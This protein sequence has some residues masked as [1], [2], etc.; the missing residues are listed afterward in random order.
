[1]QGIKQRSAK[2]F[3]QFSLEEA[4]PAD[5]I[6]RRI[7]QSLDLS[8][9]YPCTRRLYGKDGQ[10]SIDPVVFFKMCLIGYLNDITADRALCRYIQ[11]SLAARWFICHDIDEPIP[12][13]STLS[14]TRALFGRPLYEE[15]FRRVLALCVD[16]GL[17]SGTRQAVDSGLVK[18]NAS[19]DSMRRRV[20]ME[21]A[22]AWCRQVSS[23]NAAEQADSGGGPTPVELPARAPR[24]RSR[25][26]KTHQSVTDPDARLARKPGKPTDM[27]YHGQI[28]VDAQHGVIV[29]AMADYA[30]TEDHQSL[31]ALLDQVQAHLSA[32]HLRVEE[33]LADSKYNTLHTIEACE[34][35]GITAY[36]PNPSGYK[37]FRE[38][39]TF[40]EETN[41]YRCSQGVILAYKGQQ[42][43]RD[44]YNNVYASSAV[45]CAQCPIRSECITGK[46]PRKTLT[47]SSGKALYD[48]MDGR[49]QADKGRR[50]LA[51]RKGIVE[52][53]IGNLMHHNAMKKVCARGLPA[54]GKH[55]LMASI[56][57]NL[58]KWLRYGTIKPLR[59]VVS[60]GKDFLCSIFEDICLTAAQMFP[61]QSI[62]TRIP[63]INTQRY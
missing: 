20:I 50:M 57:F 42:K 14:R 28:S 35:A 12:V 40:C 3:Y 49:L 53:V 51:K 52:P 62:L 29:A 13:H 10:Q 36:M 2:L 55:V 25:S 63:A 60:M 4:V 47:H 56:S 23:E 15:V 7:E 1:M 48:R 54:A 33:L 24:K 8:F 43:C 18:A 46:A 31:P 19:I 41:S 59:K 9:L 58:K 32:H 27:Y 26:N 34:Q 61:A 5:H 39:F 44:Y 22:S 17:V 11:D 38:G 6:Y 45:D 21:D 16:A 30:D 37:R